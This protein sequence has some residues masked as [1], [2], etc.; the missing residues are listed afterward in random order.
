MSPYRPLERRQRRALLITCPCCD[1]AGEQTVCVND[2][3]TGCSH[4]SDRSWPCPAC[5]TTGRVRRSLIHR[6]DWCPRCGLSS[7]CPD[8]KDAS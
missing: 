1:G 8:C 2:G 5:K 6:D 7:T 4:Q 3:P